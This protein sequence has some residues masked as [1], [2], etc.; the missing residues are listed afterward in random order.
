MK[1]IF[2]VLEIDNCIYLNLE[3]EIFNICKFIDYSKLKVD[4]NK[5]LFDVI[6]EEIIGKILS[7]KRKINFI[8]LDLKGNIYIG[9]SY[10]NK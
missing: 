4:K 6:N 10:V 5:N 1:E 3:L 8:D 9:K 2:K 7:Y